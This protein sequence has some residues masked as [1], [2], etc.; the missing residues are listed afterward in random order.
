MWVEVQVPVWKLAL[1]E[2][3]FSLRWL[4]TVLE[5]KIH[6]LTVENTK[7]ISKGLVLDIS[8][9]NSLKYN[10][11]HLWDGLWLVLLKSKYKKTQLAAKDQNFLWKPTTM[12]W[13][14][15]SRWLFRKTNDGWL[16]LQ[17]DVIGHLFFPRGASIIYVDRQEGGVVLPNAYAVL[18]KLTVKFQ[19]E[20]RFKLRRGSNRSA[21]KSDFT[22]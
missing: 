19:I 4:P 21:Q 17:N 12:I 10:S 13:I 9:N 16:Q 7:N 20:E 22:T 5:Y 14:F 2:V 15:D 18:H 6:E 8:F 3:I 1:R 11:K